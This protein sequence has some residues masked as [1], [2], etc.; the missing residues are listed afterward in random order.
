[1]SG[2]NKVILIGNL[3]RDPELKYTNGGTPVCKLSVCTSRAWTNKNGERQEEQEWHRVSVWGKQAEH[4]N[5]YL[6]KGRSCYVEGR[7][8]TSSYDQDGIKKWSTEIVADTVQFLGGKPS[9]DKQGA[10]GERRQEQGPPPYNPQDFG[11]PA[12]DDDI[13]F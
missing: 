1:M 13:P 9:S 2:V 4:C 8:K 7:L 3:G 10:S 12:G 5:N 6:A 11:P